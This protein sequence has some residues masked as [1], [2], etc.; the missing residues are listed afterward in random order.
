MKKIIFWWLGCSLIV[1]LIYSFYHYLIPKWYP[2]DNYSPL[3]LNSEVSSSTVD[4]T[5]AYAPKV[6]EILNGHIF[7]SDLF[8]WEY[9]N[10]PSPFIG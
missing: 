10:Y 3:V 5:I 8:I 7:L 1:G 9:K 2:N 6:Q 4:E